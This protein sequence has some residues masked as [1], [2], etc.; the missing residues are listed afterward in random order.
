MLETD[1]K[2]ERMLRLAADANVGGVLLSTQPN[3][4]WLTGGRSNRIDGSRDGGNGAL[5]VTAD[6]R[7]FVLA[8]NIEAP[9]LMAEALDGLGFELLEYAWIDERADPSLAVRLAARTAGGILGSDTQAPD[10]AYLDPQIARLRTPLVPAEELRYRQFGRD[11]GR[12]VAEVAR[13]V[14]PGESEQA[15][16][17]ATAAALAT[18]D[19]RPIVLLV[20]A[21]NRIAEFRHPS[22]TP[23][24]WR[25]VVMIAT[26]AEREGLVVALSRLVSARTPP[27]IGPHACALRVRSLRR[28]WTRRGRA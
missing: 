9:R 23:V 5:L 6:G 19:A 3:F 26:C 15:I 8:N 20:A 28:S 13:R 4:S 27:T 18:I 25:E 10:A 16:A 7:R 11:A 14:T 12:V 24:R 22:P 21:D 17:G 2:I 1:A